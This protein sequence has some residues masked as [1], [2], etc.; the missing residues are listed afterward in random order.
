MAKG[1]LARP[2]LETL[3]WSPERR[4][5]SLSRVFGLAV[6]LATGEEKWYAAK[7]RPKR[8]GRVLRIGAIVL[9]AVAAV[10]PILAEISAEDDKPSIA[11]TRAFAGPIA[12]VSILPSL[13]TAHRRGPTQRNAAEASVTSAVPQPRD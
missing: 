3:E 10:L 9:G 4:S 12:A 5:E 13:T 2:D 11:P 7:R 8:C 6:G 1:D